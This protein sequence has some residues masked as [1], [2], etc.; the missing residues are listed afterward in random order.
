MRLETTSPGASAPA[1]VSAVVGK[2]CAIPQLE[3]ST[4]PGEPFNFV[5]DFVNERWVEFAGF[6]VAE[7]V[8][9]NPDDRSGPS[10]SGPK[11]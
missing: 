9:L 3:S 7:C 11:Q 10:P 8:W 5:V 6:I 4:P 2:S 1:K